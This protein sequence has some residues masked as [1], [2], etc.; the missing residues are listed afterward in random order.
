MFIILSALGFIELFICFTKNNFGITIYILWR[1]QQKK[2]KE[3]D[4]NRNI[5]SADIVNKAAHKF[6]VRVRYYSNYSVTSDY[7]IEKKI[8]VTYVN[9][10][11]I[12]NIWLQKLV[13]KVMI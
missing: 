10:R 4:S 2:K 8:D 7:V 12:I 6:V 9:N 1:I 3:E 13:K 5:E 11:L